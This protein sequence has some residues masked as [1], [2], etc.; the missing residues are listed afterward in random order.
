MTPDPDRPD[1]P[2]EGLTIDDDWVAGATVSEPPAR[3]RAA[4][5]ALDHEAAEREEQEALAWRRRRRRRRK[6]RALVLGGLLLFSAAVAVADRGDQQATTW[7]A[8]DTGEAAY[9]TLGGR[10]TARPASSDAALGT[11]ADPDA[12]GGSFRFAATQ[13]GGTEP[14]AYDPCR[15]IEIVVNDDLAPRGASALTEAAVARVADITGLDIVITGTTTEQPGSK[16]A[17][18][19]PDRYGD[20]W[21][22][23]VLAWSDEGQLP[24][25]AGNVAG[26][27]GSVATVTSD[28]P[29]VYV[30]GIVALDA[31]DLERILDDEDDGEQIVSDIV[32]HELGHLVGL[33]HVDSTDELMYPEGQ[34]DLHGYQQGDRTGLSRL[35]QGPCVSL[36]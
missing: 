3:V 20:R 25:L 24:A 15:P 11:P 23:V 33:D 26:V 19:Q 17:A 21:A 32:L 31:P 35:G 9:L 30:S 8:A 27:G 16:R 7:A 29:A 12:S 22:P 10:P 14:V 18:Y 2:F 5:A 4:R 36:L 6:N 1:D 28:G 13:P 34:P